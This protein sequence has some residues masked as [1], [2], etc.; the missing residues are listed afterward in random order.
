LAQLVLSRPLNKAA[1][2]EFR[3]DGTWS[4]PRVTEVN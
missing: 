3:I 4:Q 2:T 1:T